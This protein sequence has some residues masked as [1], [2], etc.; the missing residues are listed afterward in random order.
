MMAPLNSAFQNQGCQV[1]IH[2]LLALI[3][4]AR[5]RSRCPPSARACPLQVSKRDPSKVN[6]LSRQAQPA[7][8]KGA[9]Q[10]VLQ[11]QGVASNLGWEMSN[12]IVWRCGSQHVDPMTW[13]CGWPQ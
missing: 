4:S 12:L 10:K 8:G 5:A 9:S 6:E 13:E 7:V 1:Y 3:S 2:C 11:V